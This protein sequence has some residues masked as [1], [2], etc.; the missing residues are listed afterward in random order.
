VNKRL[1]LACSL[2]L[3][4]LLAWRT[5]WHQVAESFAHL[6]WGLWLLAAL[7]Y[8][9]MQVVSSMRWQWL[10]RPLGFGEPLRRFL[11][12]YYIG[13]FFNLA[14]PTSVGGDV[15]RAWYL[16]GGPGRRL[17]AFL[18]VFVERLSGL[19]VLL[20]IACTAAAVCPLALPWW[21][22]WSVWG[23]T[24]AGLVAVPALL[25]LALL[26][27][28][29]ARLQ[30]PHARLVRFAGQLV[31]AGRLYLRHPRLLL[32]ATLLSGIVQ[33]GNIGIVWLIGLA[34]GARV[35]AVYYWIV[36]PL[37][38]ILTLLPVSL[39]GMG[40]REGA[41]VTLLAPLGVGSGTALS[42]AFLWFAAVSAVSLT[43]VVFYLA[44]GRQGV[45]ESEAQGEDGKGAGDRQT[46]GRGHGPVG[47]DSDQGR[48]GQSPAAA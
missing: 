36:V 30:G 46:G 25:A 8:A 45:P 12:F 14:L 9:L 5:N 3:L 16:A 33:A 15:V 21:V 41:M 23:L 17:D 4:G 26:P 32:G 22:P 7:L 40:I 29:A 2:G 13:M 11:A 10:A 37:V 24:A 31:A 27:C 18:S 28:P 6:R 1:R 20:A 35:P 39:N 34:V 47:G 43:G 38:T 44:G 42:L 19:L 48:A